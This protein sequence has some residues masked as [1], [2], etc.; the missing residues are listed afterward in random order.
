[1]AD[2]SSTTPTYGETFRSH[3]IL[4]LIPVVL[5]AIVA[6]WSGLSAPK[7]Y[8]SAATLWS[9]AP[10]STTSVFGALPP[11]GQDQQLLNELLTTRYFEDTVAKK[12]PLAAY[13]KTHPSESTGI[14][15][16]LA[17]LRQTP[18]LDDRIATALGTK[19]VISDAKGPHVLELDYEAPTPTLAVQTLRAII[20]EFRRQR[21]ALREDALSASQKQVSSASDTLAS[22][23]TK[24]TLYLDQHPAT[25]RNDPQLRALAQSERQAVGA[26]SVATDNMNQATLAVSNGSSGETILRVIDP[27]GTPVAPTAG[28]KKLVEVVVAGIFAGGVLSCLGVV[29]L[30]RRKRRIAEGE[31][32]VAAPSANG[33]PPHPD[34]NPA[35]VFAEPPV[36]AAD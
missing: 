15:G 35:A 19:R 25:T 7:M 26:L 1:M 9:D 24:L 6:G 12:S 10:G 31:L 14:S 28:K 2:T 5:A 32:L 8:R 33:G 30:T 18:S 13:L 21:G 27:P 17:K 36:G 4:F 11:A 16:L 34:A 23:R 20:D 22:A 3:R 29:A